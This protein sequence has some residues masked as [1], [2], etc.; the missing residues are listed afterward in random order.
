MWTK[1]AALRLLGCGGKWGCSDPTS[2]LRLGHLGIWLSALIQYHC[3]F[4]PPHLN[5]YLS[6]CNSLGYILWKLLY[7]SDFCGTKASDISYN[8]KETEFNE[9]LSCHSPIRLMKLG[10]T[11]FGSIMSDRFISGWCVV[12]L[13]FSIWCM[14]ASREFVK[15]YTILDT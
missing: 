14:C 13:F 3:S 7:V 4:S 10:Q 15:L 9:A 1:K 12:I 5:L 6:G 8:D 2:C 11:Q